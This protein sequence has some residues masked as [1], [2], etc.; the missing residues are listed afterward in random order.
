MGGLRSVSQ[1]GSGRAEFRDQGCGDNND[2]SP[3]L[4]YSGKQSG[5]YARGLNNGSQHVSCGC[6]RLSMAVAG[7]CGHSSRLYVT[8]QHGQSSF[9]D[10]C[11]M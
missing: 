11:N 1:C 10:A 6:L 3:D 4:R 8:D 2:K 7:R 9:D 5:C